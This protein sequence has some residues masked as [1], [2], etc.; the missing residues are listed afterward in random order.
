MH[1]EPLPLDDLL[2]F[3]NDASYGMYNNIVY[4][5]FPDS[6]DVEAKSSD[7]LML[8]V[9]S[10]SLNEDYDSPSKTAYR[11]LLSKAVEA[12]RY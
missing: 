12:L 1:K 6:P 9:R 11:D 10:L 7:A 5:L 4:K 2:T 3:Y 8:I